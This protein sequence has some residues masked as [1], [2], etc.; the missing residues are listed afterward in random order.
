MNENEK[1]LEEII[2]ENGCEG[3][4]EAK[5]AAKIEEERKKWEEEYSKRLEN[6]KNEA[7]KVAKMGEEEKEKYNEENRLRELEERERAIEKRELMAEAKEILA[8]K[9][10]PLELTAI[11]D[12]SSAEACNTSIEAVALAFT[13]A[14]E[15]A[16]EEKLIGGKSLKKAQ[17]TGNNIEKQMRDAMGANY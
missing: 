5:I 7:V 1:N 3:E 12:Y 17:G 2:K 10:I 14:V 4:Y 6:E 11:L 9:K 15:A 16:T 8:E 13:K